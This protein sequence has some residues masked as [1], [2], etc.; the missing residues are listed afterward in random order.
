MDEQTST[1]DPAVADAAKAEA[2]A[3]AAA[4]KA[5]AKAAEKEK[6]DQESAV[7]KAAKEAEKAAAK[8]AAE[9]KKAATAQAKLDSK[10]AAEVAKDATKMPNQHGVTRPKA[11]TICGRA[12]AIYDA[13]SAAKGSAASIAEAKTNPVIVGMAEATVRT[14]YARWRKFYGVSG[15]IDAPKAPVAPV[16]AEPKPVATEVA[17]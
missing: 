14:Q 3:N 1:L 17:A 12:W 2:E 13:L 6:K 15:R 5:A 7:K 16:A 11:D 4:V 8:V 10:K 9:A